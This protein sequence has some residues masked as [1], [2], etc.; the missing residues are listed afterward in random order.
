[1]FAGAKQ[2]MLTDP[3]LKLVSERDYKVGDCP[4]HSFIFASEGNDPKFQRMDYVLTK[5]DLSIVV[6]AS[7]NKTAL[8]DTSCKELFQ[9]IS[10]RS[11]SAGK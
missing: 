2:N 1:M 11:K 9:S 3:N 5:P 6:F 8:D 10:V 7:P 4:A